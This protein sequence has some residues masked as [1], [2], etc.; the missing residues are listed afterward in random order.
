MLLA[1]KE[2]LPPSNDFPHAAPRKTTQLLSLGIIDIMPIL[3]RFNISDLV[4]L[5]KT[6]IYQE[7]H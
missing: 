7:H 3:A 4:L 2:L 6:V 5:G 1:D